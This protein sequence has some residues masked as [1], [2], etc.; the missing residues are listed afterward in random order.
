VIPDGF[1]PLEQ[2]GTFLD[3][4][5]GLLWRRHEDR[6]DTCLV[7][8]P[9]HLNPNGTAHGGL[10]LTM[11]D[12]TL[13]AT[14]E[15]YLGV[16]D[17]RHPATIQLSTS[18]L[19]PARDGELVLGEAVVDGSSRTVTFV[20][21]RLHCAGRSLLTASAVFRNPAPQRA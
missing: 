19:A 12:I 14:A 1:V 8:E 15:S 16:V 2:G 21:G 3:H 13:G 17:G 18:M 9:H 6:T 7:L 11:L 5:G 10:L 20:S 4:V